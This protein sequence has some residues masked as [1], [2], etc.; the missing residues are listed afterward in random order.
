MSELSNQ[1]V[2]G[3]IGPDGHVPSQGACAWCKEECWSRTVLPAT[4]LSVPMHLL[5]T[6][7]LREAYRRNQAGEHLRE[8]AGGMLN[9]ADYLK[10]RQAKLAEGA[11]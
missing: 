5:C 7:D 2:V 6:S 1:H 8:L 10:M 11:R 4:G 3:A 9:L